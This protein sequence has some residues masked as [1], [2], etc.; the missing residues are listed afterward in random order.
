[1]EP[2][3]DQDWGNPCYQYRLGDEGLESS[4]ADK[5]LGVPV[6]E[7]P[8][9]S[10]QCT[11][12]AQKA[13][14]VLGCIKEAWLAGRGRWLCSGETPPGILCPAL[15]PS[16]QEGHG[17]VGEGPEQGHENDHRGTS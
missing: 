1:M 16:A 4:A 3:T 8:D 17:P 7:K 2:P 15:E 5:D 13:S 10:R 12:T 9:V 14:C 6:G 11:L